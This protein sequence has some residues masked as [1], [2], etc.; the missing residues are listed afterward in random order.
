[1][2]CFVD[3]CVTIII[4]SN[5]FVQI[6]I[7]IVEIS[8]F[9]NSGC[10][11]AKSRIESIQDSKIVHLQSPAHI[12]GHRYAANT[13]NL[14]LWL[15]SSVGHKVIVRVLKIDV[16][17]GTYSLLRDTNAHQSNLYLGIKEGQREEEYE[18]FGIRDWSLPRPSQSNLFLPI[19]RRS[20]GEIILGNDGC[21]YW[22]PFNAKRVL[23]F[24]PET[25]VTS[26]V[27]NAFGYNLKIDGAVG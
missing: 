2:Q 25:Q 20:D 14:G 11:L 3:N 23:K 6:D 10:C 7:K 15:W 24:D 26:L 1:V 22:P 17:N 21:V 19:G 13:S 12:N 9:F 27:G 16:V 4:N 8:L 5:C 18:Y